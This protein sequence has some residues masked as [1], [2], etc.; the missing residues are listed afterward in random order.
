MID[1]PF[2][3]VDIA[4]GETI[5]LSNTHAR[6]VPAGLFEPIGPGAIARTDIPSGDP[7]L[8]SD[9]GQGDAPIPEGWWIVT[10]DLPPSAR[11]GDPVR[12]VLVDTGEVIDG[13]VASVGDPDA[14]TVG[15]GAVAIPGDRAAAVASAAINGRVVVMVSTG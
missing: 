9:V 10:V 5:T 2:A 7:I 15:G 13:L 4:R 14:F 12:M 11:S 1:H 8:A 6:P 3:T